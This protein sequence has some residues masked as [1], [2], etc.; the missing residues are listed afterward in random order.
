[1]DLNIGSRLWLWKN[2]RIYVY[3]IV[4][5]DFF[6]EQFQYEKG[7]DTPS[8]SHKFTQVITFTPENVPHRFATLKNNQGYNRKTIVKLIDEDKNIADALLNKTTLDINKNYFQKYLSPNQFETLIFL[9]FQANGI[10]AS[11]HN[12]GTT[13]SYDFLI[14]HAFEIKDN[15]II[16][17]KEKSIKLVQVKQRVLKKQSDIKKT[18]EH[19]D[20]LFTLDK[21]Y[22]K[23][24]SNEP[25]RIDISYFELIKQ[26]ENT[27]HIKKW[28]EFEFNK[29]CFKQ[30]FIS[31]FN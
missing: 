14:D 17:L 23:G 3:S 13:E 5:N 26:S 9:L 27:I 25:L 4:G 1:M 10:T 24:S 21:L 30:N 29:K 2:G 7:K 22:I 31:L 19:N 12:G 15:K 11:A 18:L 8:V 16:K 20:F 28:L 6:N